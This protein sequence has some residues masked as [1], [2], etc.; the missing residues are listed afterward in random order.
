MD[1][2]Y[3]DLVVIYDA[4]L[5]RLELNI[6][7]EL[8]TLMVI[9]D[10]E[11]FP[12]VLSKRKSCFSSDLSKFSIDILSKTSGFELQLGLMQYLAYAYY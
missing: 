11:T 12:F 9:N 8:C 7:F 6:D 1:D 2:C 3:K 5:Q 10:M 4:M